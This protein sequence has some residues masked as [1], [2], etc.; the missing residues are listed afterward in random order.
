M[1]A[2]F[3]LFSILSTTMLR[4]IE[5][6]YVVAPLQQYEITDVD[7][8]PF[9]AGGVPEVRKQT[10]KKISK[11]R[12]AKP[13]LTNS[14]QPIPFISKVIFKFLSYAAKWDN[15]RE[16][17]EAVA[18]HCKFTG[19]VEAT[20]DAGNSTTTNAWKLQTG[21]RCWSWLKLTSKHSTLWIP[22]LLST[23]KLNLIPDAPV[24]SPKILTPI[25]ITR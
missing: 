16:T 9:D 24:R 14:Q 2:T 10:D 20:L 3:W 25:I 22:I 23:N 7:M 12:I 4:E 18:V 5:C 21:T 19:R 1:I 11:N 17:F 8:S 13:V 6:M 15:I